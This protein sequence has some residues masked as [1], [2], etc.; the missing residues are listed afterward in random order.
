VFTDSPVTA[1]DQMEGL[2]SQFT[3]LDDSESTAS[4]AEIFKPIHVV[5]VSLLYLS[6]NGAS[7]DCI[8]AP[9]EFLD[10]ITFQSGVRRTDPHSLRYLGGVERA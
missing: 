6:A 3:V 2:E 7:I 10:E 8:C 5:P 1:F 4:V 9:F